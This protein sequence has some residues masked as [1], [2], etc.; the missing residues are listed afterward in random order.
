MP[1]VNMG[2]HSPRDLEGFGKPSFGEAQSGCAEVSWVNLAQE[3]VSALRHQGSP[4]SSSLII[5]HQTSISS[6]S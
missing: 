2:P 5:G 6:M 3:S 4:S 1:L